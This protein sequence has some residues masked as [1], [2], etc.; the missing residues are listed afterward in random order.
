MKNLRGALMAAS[1]AAAIG[2]GDGSGEDLF[3]G[4]PAPGTGGAGASG[5]SWCQYR[6][7]ATRSH[8]SS[9]GRSL[10]Q[11]AAPQRGD[12]TQGMPLAS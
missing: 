2:C 9:S 4:E 1:V 11:V 12:S 5:T 8:R 7:P 3:G 10:R 6:R